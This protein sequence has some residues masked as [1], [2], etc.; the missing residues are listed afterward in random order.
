MSKR[1]LEGRMDWADEELIAPNKAK[2]AQQEINEHTGSA[3]MAAS[4]AFEAIAGEL[5]FLRGALTVVCMIAGGLTAG[6]ILTRRDIR[7]F[8]NAMNEG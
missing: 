8:T 6:L 5:T 3:L 1:D 4:E 2:N 7:K